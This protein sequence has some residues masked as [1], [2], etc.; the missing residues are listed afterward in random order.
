[1]VNASGFGRMGAGEKTNAARGSGWAAGRPGLLGLSPRPMVP[2]LAG[3][4]VG[5]RGRSVFTKPRHILKCA[6]VL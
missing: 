1:M 4:G 2:L 6:K 3:T 5:K